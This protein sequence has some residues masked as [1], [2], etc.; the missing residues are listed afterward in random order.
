M[1]FRFLTFYLENYWSVDRNGVKFGTL[2]VRI[3]CI[4]GN[5]EPKITKRRVK[6]S[7]IWA[8]GVSIQSI[9]GTF[10]S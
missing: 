2:G 5:F 9:Q 4:Q 7:E 8:S 1:H 3:Q 6:R 10:D